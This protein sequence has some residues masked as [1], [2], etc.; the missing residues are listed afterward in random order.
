MGST[1]KNVLINLALPNISLVN[2][3]NYNPITLYHNTCI[4]IRTRPNVNY[5][6]I[7]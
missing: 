3:G 6:H 5:P 7:K 4:I 2:P 1:N